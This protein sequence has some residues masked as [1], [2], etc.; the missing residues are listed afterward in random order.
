MKMKDQMRIMK[1]EWM[2]IL[3]M[4]KKKKNNEHFNFKIEFPQ[5]RFTKD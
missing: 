3:M 2:W 4:R 1:K 5:Q